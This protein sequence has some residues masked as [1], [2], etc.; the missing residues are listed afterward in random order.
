MSK[1]LEQTIRRIVQEELH[2][3]LHRTITIERGPR[4]QEDSERV[5]RDEEWHVLDFL[6]A[7]LPKIEGALRGMQEDVDHVKNEA[8]M[9]TKKLQV[10][11]ETLLIAERRAQSVERTR[12]A[13]PPHALCGPEGTP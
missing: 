5:V 9:N 8:V 6:A 2:Q 11:G 1:K 7:Y 13:M 3:A 12:C 4:Q 10:I